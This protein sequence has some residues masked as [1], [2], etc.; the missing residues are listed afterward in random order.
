MN[1]TRFF[2]FSL[3]I[4]TYWNPYKKVERPLV[5]KGAYSPKD[6]NPGLKDILLLV[7]QWTVLFSLAVLPYLSWLLAYTNALT[8]SFTVLLD[9]RGEG[10]V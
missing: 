8:Q 10:S 6:R 4:I 2:Q 7:E 1:L 5:Q 9:W 3:S